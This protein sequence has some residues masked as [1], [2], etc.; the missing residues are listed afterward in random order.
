ME[1]SIE[2]QT[3]DVLIR[4]RRAVENAKDAAALN[5]AYQEYL[6]KRG[7]LRKLLR[8]VG[9]LSPHERPAQGRFVHNAI[10]IV[11][12]LFSHKLGEFERKEEAHVLQHERLDVTIPA[13]KVHRGRLHVLTEMR[14]EVERIFA[15][16]GF[17]VASGPEVEDAWHNFDA[18]NIPEDHP[19]RDLWDTLWLRS[20]Q[21]IQNPRLH[22]SFGGQ[23][24]SN[25]QNPK[26]QLLLRTHTSPVQ[27]RYM[28]EHQLPFRI[29]VP[30]R[31][32]RFEA[33]DATHEVQFWQLEGLM[34][35]QRDDPDAV[36]AGHFLWI[37]EQFYSQLFR[38]Q[39]ATRLRPSFFPFT[40]PSFEVDMRCL[41]C[42]G[43]G[44]ASCGHS[45]WLEMMGA[46]MV[47]PKVFRSVGL[48]PKDVQ[49][50]AFGMGLER[51]CMMKYKIPD[52][53]LFRGGDVRFLQQF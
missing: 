38:K 44:C 21:K 2:Q 7:I 47:H 34:V 11:E 22:K 10:A 17:S 49:G 30:G 9:E 1:T 52:I 12:E 36:N 42:G 4:A 37:I 28:V 3:K 29:I 53:R 26:G 33:T 8:S 31:V 45:G 25:P 14:R 16:L 50:F 5:V 24:K 19:A 18:L 46:G 32:Y 15:G 35:S 41:F 51:L 20:N 39:I 27:I 23:A 13:K 48:N 43:R 6:G 40:E